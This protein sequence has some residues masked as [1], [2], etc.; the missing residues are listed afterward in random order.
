MHERG[1][2]PRA[3]AAERMAERNRTPVHIGAIFAQPKLTHDGDRLHRDYPL[4]PSWMPYVSIMVLIGMGLGILEGEL[5]AVVARKWG[6][7][8]EYW[9][10]VYDL[11]TGQ[12]TAKL[13]RTFT[14]KD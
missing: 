14:Y 12:I 8:I 5:I 6:V 11:D 4:A 9:K 10:A 2:E 7:E 13:T 1:H 3:R